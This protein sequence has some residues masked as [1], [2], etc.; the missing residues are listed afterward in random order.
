MLLPKRLFIS[1]KLGVCPLLAIDF[2][3]A[4]TCSIGLIV[5]LIP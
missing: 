2:A 4:S 3:A 5:G 1:A